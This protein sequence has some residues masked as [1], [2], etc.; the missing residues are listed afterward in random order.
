MP[1]PSA[2]R[3]LPRIRVL[4]L[5]SLVMSCSFVCVFLAPP[6]YAGRPIAAPRETGSGQATDRLLRAVRGED[7]RPAAAPRGGPR[8]A[9]LPS[10]LGGGGRRPDERS[11][12]T[13]LAHPRSPGRGPASRAASFGSRR[14]PPAR[15]LP[16]RKRTKA[17]T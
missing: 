6:R 16:C 8:P 5:A 1:A 13:P 15:Q 14:R 12:A 3:R 4:G 9:P 11:A 7:C 17:V 2:D 10:I